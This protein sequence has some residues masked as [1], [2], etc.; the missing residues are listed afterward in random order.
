L[1]GRAREEAEKLGLAPEDLVIVTTEVFKGKPPEYHLE[2]IIGDPISYL[3]KRA[4]LVN[5]EE[6]AE[7]EVK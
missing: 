7:F 1:Q 4:G 6:G 3:L 5:I 2:K